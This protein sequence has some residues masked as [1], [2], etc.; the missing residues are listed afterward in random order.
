MTPTKSPV[1]VRRPSRNGLT[2]EV[3]RDADTYRKFGIRVSN[4]TRTA[5]CPLDVIPLTEDEAIVAGIE[6]LN[7]TSAIFDAQQATDAY[8]REILAAC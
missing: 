8:I 4:G 5:I 2:I 1:I 6:I 7:K 3:I